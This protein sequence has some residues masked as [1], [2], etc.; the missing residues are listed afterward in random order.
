MCMRHME[1]FLLLRNHGA[2]HD[3]PLGI[4]SEIPSGPLCY[5]KS[6]DISKSLK[7]AARVH[8]ADFGIG[9][10]YVSAGCLRS[11][12]AMEIFCGGNDSSH[13]GLLGRWQSCTMLSYLHLQSRASMHVLSAAMLQG[14]K[15]NIPPPGILP[16]IFPKPLDFPACITPTY[17]ELYETLWVSSNPP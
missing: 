16:S 1:L 11:I 17:G 15:I 3:A 6:S 5:I 8:G 9:P 2:P 7:S 12:G 14:G 4:Y 13:I 10:D